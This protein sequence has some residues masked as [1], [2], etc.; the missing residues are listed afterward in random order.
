VV[1]GGTPGYTFGVKSFGGTVYVAAGTPLSPVPKLVT[2]LPIDATHGYVVTITDS[3][4]NTCITS[5]LTIT[6]PSPLIV[7]AST[8]I[9]VL[10]YGDNTGEIDLLI[11]GG[12][13]PY[14]VSTTGIGFSSNTL[15][16]TGLLAGSYVTNVVDNLGAS[17]TITTVINT[18]NALM[19]LAPSTSV[20][21]QCDPTQYLIPFYI[22]A[23]ATAGPVNI[24]YSI[25]GNPFTLVVM[26]YVN[27]TTPLVLSISSPPVIAISLK[28][29]LKNSAGCVSSDLVIMASSITLP[30]SVLT[31]S[32]STSGPVSGNYSHVVTG[33]GG[34]APYTGTG[35]FV[36]TNPTLTTSISDNV[37]CTS[38]TVTG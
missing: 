29:H 19:T 32:I 15:T 9:D 2:G 8:V 34:F 18:I 4:S 38:A 13:A 28:I 25:D 11:V 33:S 7:S 22:T 21:M 20:N 16:M 35:T 14:T 3:A 6:G 23:G 36:D 1:G 30:S 37:G 17:A 5:G 12:Q 26:T 27:S 31:C 10:C 24:E